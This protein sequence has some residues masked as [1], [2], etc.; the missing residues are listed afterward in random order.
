MTALL[1][2]ESSKNPFHLDSRT[3]FNSIYEWKPQKRSINSIKSHR[4][5]WESFCS[6]THCF[7]YEQRS[8]EI[9]DQLEITHRALFPGIWT[10]LLNRAMKS[11]DLI[12][13]CSNRSDSL[14]QLLVESLMT[15][16]STECGDKWMNE[17]N[18]QFLLDST[19]SRL[20]LVER[21]CLNV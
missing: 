1:I 2:N 5:A 15:R 20:T 13:Y 3:F 6:F 18:H 12:Q 8:H 16:Q 10:L 19:S 14:A 17:W 21:F 9:I 4:I 7:N 11:F